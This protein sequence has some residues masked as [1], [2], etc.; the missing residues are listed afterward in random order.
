MKIPKKI[1][2]VRRKLMRALTSNVGN[3]HSVK[4]RHQTI[5]VG[6][7]R[8][9]ITR[10]NSR[11]G[12]LL[13]ITPLV[14]EVSAMFPE[15]KIDLF[16]RGNA[17]P[18]IFLNYKNIGRIVKLPAKPFQNLMEYVLTWM[19][20]RKFHYDLV[21]N[22][23]QHSSSGR[24]S[25]LFANADYRIF[26]EIDEKTPS[27]TDENHI[28]KLPVYSFR[29]YMRQLGFQIKNSP[30]PTL[31]LKL[32][33]FELA[34]GK[35]ALQKLADEKKK[36]ICIF[37]YATGE[38]C[39]TKDWWLH[40][41]EQLKQCY[42]NYNI[43]EILPAHNES[44]INFSAPSFY[45]NNI[46]EIGA[47]MANADLF[48]GADSGIMHLASSVQTTVVGLFSVSSLQKYAPYGN[49]S[50]AIDTNQGTI[51]DWFKIL[52]GVLAVAGSQHRKRTEAAG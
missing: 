41:Y 4:R 36:T 31:D 33:N 19:S 25:A 29:N 39:Y 2:E 42:P 11:L 20:L 16:V 45:S 40:F 47:V 51:E 6:V 10:P 9:L 24:L 12:N 48:I 21:I 46:R 3:S 22:A 17:A 13:L 35:E 32:T 43:V 5:G 38:K 27:N 49:H 23:D 26:G 8:V 28:A 52:T 50:V 7:K 30:I 15:C 34:R 14:K 18:V 1:N 44:Q 37:T